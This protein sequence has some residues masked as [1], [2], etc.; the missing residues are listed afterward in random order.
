MK[1]M[2]CFIDADAWLAIVD[3]NDENHARARTFFEYLLERDIKLVS[4]N[5]VIDKTLDE[6]KNRFDEDM[7]A[8]F[9]KI[10]EEAVITI[11][12]RLDWIS[13]RIRRTAINN[14]LRSTHSE[15][16]LYHFYIKETI[17]RKKVD[18]IFSFDQRLAEFGIPVMSQVN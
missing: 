10:I 3:R 2:T 11:N 7:A 13:K 1:I 5:Y 9:M 16:T 6:L 8:K 4:N 18:I 15:L 12:L 17:K 14:F